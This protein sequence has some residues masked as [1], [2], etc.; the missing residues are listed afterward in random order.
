MNIGG[1]RYN[2]ARF[3]AQGFLD[4]SFFPTRSFPTDNHRPNPRSAHRRIEL[5]IADFDTKEV[6]QPRL[7]FYG[8]NPL[9]YSMS[10]PPTGPPRI[11]W[12]VTEATV[13]L[14]RTIEKLCAPTM[15]GALE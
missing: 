5:R 6:H 10:A 15:N 7:P 8:E 4:R 11:F 13:T 12:P 2:V 1:R 3:K 9:V 14:P